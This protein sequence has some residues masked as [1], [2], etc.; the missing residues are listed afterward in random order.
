MSLPT[1]NLDDRRFQDL[2]DDAK[3]RIATLCPEWTDHNVSDPGVTL[4]ET[5]AWMVEQL[6]YR[7]NRVPD[8]LY[9]RFLEMLGVT[10]FP[11]VAAR[12]DV[13]FWLTAPQ[14]DTVTIPEHTELATA[15]TDV[16]EPIGF[17]TASELPITP[18]A[19]IK[20][21]ASVGNAIRHHSETLG[22]STGFD[23]FS[24]TPRPGDA[25]LVGL[26]HT[27]GSCAVA[28]RLAIAK[29]S[30]A[31]I[32]PNNPPL[33]WEAWDGAAWR[34]CEVDRDETG[35]L[36][37]SGEIVIHVPP[38]HAKS[39]LDRQHAAW[40]RCLVAPNEPGQPAFA[41]SPTIDGVTAF[42]VGGTVPAVQAETILGE[43]IGVSEG[44]PGQR[45][46][47]RRAPVLADEP[48]LIESLGPSGRHEWTEV[49]DFGDSG[50]P[51]RHFSVDAATGEVAFGPAVRQPDG[52]LRR[53][54]A[55]PAKGDTLIVR[56]YRTGGGKRGNV[57]R[58][59]INV[60]KTSLPY[61][62]SA[63][64]RGAAVG[65][66]DA[67]DIENAKV[68]GPLALRSRNRAVTAE[69]YEH[70]ALQ[71][72][73]SVAR[74]LCTPSGSGSSGSGP[75]NPG[76]GAVQVLIVPD[77]P[78]EAGKLAFERLEPSEELKSAVAAY[79][80]ERRIVGTQLRVNPPRYRGATVV[81]RLR[82]RPGG[83]ERELQREALAALY[84]Y[85]HPLRG[86]PGGAGW[87][88]GRSLHTG[89]IYAV[90]HGMPGIE[91][92]EEVQVFPANPRTGKREAPVQRLD[93]SPDEL[94][95][96]FEHQVKVTAP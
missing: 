76:P 27:V 32:D 48:I 86:G 55:T 9:V 22:G 17:T 28:L 39:V 35:G 58:G 79:L 95:F 67:E 85:L 89:E 31:G 38:G 6:C 30:G 92:V 52:D 29:T 21:A 44:V 56:R 50:E 49:P 5:F 59:A 84:G 18:C 42:T 7:L 41:S 16:A 24:P 20:L 51:D 94:I 78:D 68:R 88:F 25:L 66:V 91:L 93:L 60:I 87:P 64:N 96:S 33:R 81:A 10:L 70:L 83:D 62:K 71:A 19:V 12:A 82:A 53:H 23:C 2:V 72:S 11:P 77:V 69:D 36:N 43:T 90:F 57:A 15:R 46:R 37:R 54:G 40:L 45:F 80:D 14:V 47:L 1:P 75:A 8:R 61:V 13:T 73:H 26:S 74:A 65:G 34:S 63:E 3:R 4:I